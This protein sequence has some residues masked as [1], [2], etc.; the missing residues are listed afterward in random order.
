MKS[1]DW[2]VLVAY[3]FVLLGVAFWAFKK[4]KNSADFYIGGGNVPWWLAGA[5]HHVSGYSAVIFTG[6]AAIAY[7]MGIT[8]YIWWACSIALAMF[9]G[10]SLIAPRWVR[11]RQYLDIQ[12]PTGY[13]SQRYDIGTQQLIAWSGV[14]LKLLDV[15]AKW[16]AI[17]VVLNGFTGMELRTGIFIGSAL[18]VVYITVGGFWADLVNDFFQFIIQILAGCV[19]FY[20]VVQHLGGFSAVVDIWKK[21]PAGHLDLFPEPYT[22]TYAL[23]YTIVVFMS[24]NGGTWNLAMRFISTTD[25]REAKRTARFS[26]ILYLLWPLVLFFPMWAAPLLF[27]DLAKPETVY[28]LMSQKFLPAG[29]FGLVLAGMISATLTMTASDTNAISAVLTKDIFPVL[30]PKAFKRDGLS[31]TTAR[32]TTVIFTVITVFIAL[33]NERFGGITGLIISWFGALVGPASTP[34]LLGLLP[35][36]KHCGSG[37]AVASILGGFATFALFKFVPA[38][39]SIAVGFPAL[40]SVL[41]FTAFEFMGR[42]RPVPERVE[43]IVA[44]ASGTL[45]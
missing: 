44:A 34:M 36:Y 33:N 43:K 23:L 14:L 1:L 29:L 16:V 32:L 40:V 10:S 26:A 21:L 30:F 27:P 7:R 20:L 5:S 24:Y 9:V 28:S 19:M 35:F 25:P 38:P 6:Y 42:G 39:L 37:A 15:A 18:S 4:V 13:L 3:S 17:A 31:L 8:I 11:L 12:S 41:T 2:I 45:K 22:L